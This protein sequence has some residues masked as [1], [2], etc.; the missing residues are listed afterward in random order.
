M[1]TT[2]RQKKKRKLKKRRCLAT[3]KIRFANLTEALLFVGKGD[4]GRYFYRCFYCGDTHITKKR[5]TS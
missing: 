2:P 5:R 3:G 1:T 4:P